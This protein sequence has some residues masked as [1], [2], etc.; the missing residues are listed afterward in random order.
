MP[1]RITDIDDS[2]GILK[3]FWYHQAG[4]SYP[5]NFLI[6]FE[7]SKQQL[8]CYLSAQ[9]AI[10]MPTMPVAVGF[11]ICRNHELG[12]HVTDI[13]DFPWLIIRERLNSSGWV[14]DRE[15]VAGAKNLMEAAIAAGEYRNTVPTAYVRIYQ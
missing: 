11:V 1:M 14:I 7:G 2:R 10:R 8:E 13:P 5:Q 15:H 12:M 9:V 4:K 6:H 3:S